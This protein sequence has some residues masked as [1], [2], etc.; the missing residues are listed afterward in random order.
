VIVS[1]ASGA[2]VG[3]V[4][5]LLGAPPPYA[6]V[7]G[8]GGGL[9]ACAAGVH[10][11]TVRLAVGNGRILLG[12][13]PWR[14]PNRTVPFDLV[15]RAGTEELSLP[16]VFGL[17]IPFNRL[18]TRMTVRPGLALVLS[19]TSGEVVRVSTPRP[20]LAVALINQASPAPAD[21]GLHPGGP[22]HGVQ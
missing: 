3:L 16:Q 20:D 19:L 9:A 10:Q 15:R 8:A 1:V 18:T 6:I 14:W 4:P 13:G 12:Q 22:C 11:A 5:F 21:I 7:V 2:L 17:G